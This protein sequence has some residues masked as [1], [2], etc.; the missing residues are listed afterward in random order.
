MAI[1]I[2]LLILTAYLLGSA[3][4]AILLCRLYYGEDIRNNGSGNPGATNVQRTYGWKMGVVVFFIDAMKGVAAVEMARLSTLTPGTEAFI[5]LQSGLGLSTMLGHIFPIF[6]NFKGGKGV[7]VL[8]GILAAMQPWTMLVCFAVF[9]ATLSVCRYIS[10]SVL[11]AILAYP[12]IL[13]T[14][15]IV[16]RIFSIVA[17]VIIWLSH[18][19]NIKRIL[20]HNESKFKIKKAV[21][22]G[23]SDCRHES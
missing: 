12:F 16:L 19:S 18:L 10:L 5:A 8:C 2:I 9:L 7:A 14:D 3:S 17:V 23:K 6:F 22:P 4:S 21:R 13:R 11:I 1:S 15:S 20:S